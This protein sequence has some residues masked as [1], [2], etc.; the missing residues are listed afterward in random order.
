[1]TATTAMP[2]AV[3]T[4][5]ARSCGSSVA[6]CSSGT[7]AII[8]TSLGAR[9]RPYLRD[10]CLVLVMVRGV[11]R[12]CR[13]EWSWLL[14]LLCCCLC[15]LLLCVEVIKC[16]KQT[17]ATTAATA[18]A[19]EQGTRSHK[20]ARTSVLRALRSTSRPSCTAWMRP[21]TT[22]AIALTRASSGGSSASGLPPVRLEGMRV[23]PLKLAAA[24]VVLSSVVAPMLAVAAK[25]SGCGTDYAQ[26]TFRSLLLVL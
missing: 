10:I 3:R 11:E 6:L 21:L 13:C 19:K 24:A 12:V 8:S 26:V 14:V 23:R 2:D 9:G 18:A 25:Q 7:A 20:H 15:N 22:S 17:L 16:L 4:G 1:M 5:L